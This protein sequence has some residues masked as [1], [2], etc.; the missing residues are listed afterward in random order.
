MLAKILVVESCSLEAKYQCSVMANIDQTT[1][2][3]I[4]LDMTRCFMQPSGSLVAHATNV[5]ILGLGLTGAF[6]YQES[7]REEF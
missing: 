4:R 3:K 7:L 2:C 1:R 5:Q 6:Q